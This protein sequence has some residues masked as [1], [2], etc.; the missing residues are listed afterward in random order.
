MRN[1]FGER[2]AATTAATVVVG[3]GYGS[4]RQPKPYG[5]NNIFRRSNECVF[6]AARKDKR[7]LLLAA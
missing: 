2:D 4:Q 1:E 5:F 7:L 3:G 6:Y